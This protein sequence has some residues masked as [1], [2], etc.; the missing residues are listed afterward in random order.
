MAKVG[1]WSK[2]QVAH[3]EEVRDANC[4]LE[5]PFTKKPR[6]R[7]CRNSGEC[8]NLAAKKGFCGPCFE[9]WQEAHAAKSYWDRLWK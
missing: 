5:D 4:S 3:M 2:E 9:E 1:G 6:P 8:G 7:L